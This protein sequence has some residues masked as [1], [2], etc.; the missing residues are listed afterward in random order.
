MTDEVDRLGS[1]QRP[2]A[3]HGD[4]SADE[5]LI[6]RRVQKECPQVAHGVALRRRPWWSIVKDCPYHRTVRPQKDR[7]QIA[8]ERTSRSGRSHASG[9]R[10]M[11]AV[12][13]VTCQPAKRATRFAASAA[14]AAGVAPAQASARSE[15]G[16]PKVTNDIR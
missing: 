14:T 13:R 2:L 9:K 16:S 10:G 5:A 15:R 4:V 1:R 12:L 8:A 6:R 7:I 3:L 11:P